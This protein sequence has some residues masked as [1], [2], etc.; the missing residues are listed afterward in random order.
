MNTSAPAERILIQRA[1]RHD[2]DAFAELV[3]IYT[4]SLYRVIRRM[5]ADEQEAEAVIQETFWRIW[6]SLARYQEDQPFFPYAATIATNLVRDAWRKDRRL[7]PNDIEDESAALPAEGPT[8]ERQVEEKERLET[9]AAATAELPP[10]YRAVIALRYDAGMSY[11]NIAQ[12]LDLPVNTVR[13]HLRRAKE[14]LRK[15]METL[16]G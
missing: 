4:P 9:L 15:K 6:R 14:A 13:T 3:E 12:A 2:E 16:Y 8:P 5:V 7:L 10:H 11:A 1:R